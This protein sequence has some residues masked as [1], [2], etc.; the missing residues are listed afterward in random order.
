MVMFFGSIAYESCSWD[1]C[2]S[3]TRCIVSESMMRCHLPS[4]NVRNMQCNVQVHNSVMFLRYSLVLVYMMIC[5]H[6]VYRVSSGT[7]DEQYSDF[8]CIERKCEKSTMHVFRFAINTQYDSSSQSIN[9][10]PVDE[11]V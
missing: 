1:H 6:S 7:L 4:V 2:L 3:S 8:K 11:V 9:S 5:M 10:T